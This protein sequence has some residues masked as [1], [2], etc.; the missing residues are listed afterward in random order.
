MTFLGGDEDISREGPRRGGD[1][2]TAFLSGVLGNESS[3]LE[4]LLLLAEDKISSSCF[5]LDYGR[6]PPVRLSGVIG[7]LASD[8]S[9]EL[10]YGDDSKY[11]YSLGGPR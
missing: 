1:C 10:T 4:I 9:G 11:A 7:H 3:N 6:L 5:N 8:L 2:A